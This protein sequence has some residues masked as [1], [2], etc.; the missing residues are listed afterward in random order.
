[1][2]KEE[3]KNIDWTLISKNLFGEANE[4]EKSEY[5]TWLQAD[6]KHREYVQQSKAFYAQA[7]ESEISRPDTKEAVL[8]FKK[9]INQ[10]KIR[11][12][13]FAVI[14]K[15]AAVILLPIAVA[16]FVFLNTGQL[17]EDML[18]SGIEIIEPGSSKAELL[19]ADGKTLNLEQQDT[20][21]RELDGTQIQNLSGLLTYQS[22]QKLFEKETFNTLKIPRGG[23]YQIE[24]ADGTKVWL[25]SASS[26]K[27]PVKFIGDQRIVYLS[28]E[29]YF[30]VAH[31]KE[32]P[33]IV[34]VD[35]VN[36]KVLGTEF[37][38]KAY[39]E[40]SH[41]Q[42]TLINGKVEVLA[43][44]FDKNLR[45][46]LTPSLQANYNKENKALDVN[47]VNTTIY[48]AWKDGL[49]ILDNINLEDLSVILSRWYNVDFFFSNEKVKT[50][51]FT[52]RMKKYE[53]LQDIFDLLEQLSDVDFIIKKNAVIVQEK[54]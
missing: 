52:G 37:N 46:I 50:N 12:I 22:N 26:F 34:K 53:N 5:Q 11:T 44:G 21:V 38:V 14:L 19:L 48:T 35:D 1:M 23:E 27:Y 15:Y 49:F 32:K 9:R 54:V 47:Q 51:T 29:A 42:T 40:E 6:P 20:L 30:E 17:E 3:Y 7:E 41:I 28:G 36:V 25:N 31:D 16:T 10:N 24:L 13:N 33:F 45:T 2:N 43:K 18:A 8:A 4:V 39:P